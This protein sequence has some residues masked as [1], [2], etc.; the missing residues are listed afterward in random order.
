M[1]YFLNTAG[2]FMLF[3]ALPYSASE[4]V[5]LRGFRPRGPGGHLWLVGGRGADVD[6]PY[7]EICV[8][9]SDGSALELTRWFR[10]LVIL[11]VSFCL[12]SCLC[13]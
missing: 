1:P 3:L 8:A 4:F 12:R 11:L 6:V 2:I 13:W 5:L 7:V 10:L 9:D